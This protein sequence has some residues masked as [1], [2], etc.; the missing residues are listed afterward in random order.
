[1][2]KKTKK[3]TKTQSMKK[4]DKIFS[5]YWRKTIGRCEQCGKK[6]NLNLAHIISRS[7]KK[8]RYSPENKVILCWSC[9]WAFHSK[10]LHFAEF[11]KEKKGEEGYKN[12]IRK[13][14]KL[15]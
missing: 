5:E 2:K 6:E 15:S 3:P 11:I 10:P 4:A 1:M 12:L 9:H 8:L 7:C 13:S 14:N